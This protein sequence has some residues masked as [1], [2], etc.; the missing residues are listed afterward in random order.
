MVASPM[1]SLARRGE[2]WQSTMSS[3]QVHLAVWLFVFSQTLVA[4]I[5][6]HDPDQWLH[7]LA[8]SN[9]LVI[10]AFLAI[11]HLLSETDTRTPARPRDYS[12]FGCVVL[13]SIIGSLL[14]T[15]F[16]IAFLCLP[17][18]AHYLLFTRYFA[19]SKFLSLIYTALFVN[20]FLAPLIFMLFKSTVLVGEV[21]LAV[22]VNTLLGMDISSTGTRLAAEDGL[23]LQMIGGCSVF[24]NLSL[25]FLGYAAFKAFVRQPF[26]RRDIWFLAGLAVCLILM[27]TIRIG[28]MIPD[29]ER[30]QF[31]H[32]GDGAV[33]FAG[34]QLVVILIA[35]TVSIVTRRPLCR[36]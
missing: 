7:A 33:W 24:S 30:Y 5:G 25:A 2:G 6:I 36:V 15:R 9:L 14:G 1:T 28:L 4:K 8:K 18:A 23:R 20:G 26:C 13:F 12:L 29:V 17:I 3:K 27:N 10:A 22:Y 34:A 35:T 31:W 21:E 16:D 32:H 19:D 11:F